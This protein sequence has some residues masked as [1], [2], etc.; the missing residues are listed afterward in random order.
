MQKIAVFKKLLLAKKGF[1]LIELL[2]VIA[3]L[4]V[5]AAVV[6]VAIDPAQQLARGRDSGRKT[7]IGQLGRSL[8]AYYTSNQGYPTAI[9]WTTAPNILVTFGEIKLF[10]SN[11]AYIAGTACTTNMYPASN[12]FC[13]NIGTVAGTPES[14]I[15]ARMESKSENS[16]CA[17]GPAW[18]AWSSA[19]GRAGVVCGAAEPIAAVLVFEP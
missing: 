6:L 19:N 11:P 3:V 1:T 12:G 14:V 9:Q 13:Y 15:Y 16:K 4:G 8:Q 2:I 17:V 5:L 7:S 10:P 18:F